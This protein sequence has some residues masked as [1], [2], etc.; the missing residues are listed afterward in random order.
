MTQHC[1]YIDRPGV[2][3]HL[4]VILC[5]NLKNITKIDA[6]RYKNCINY[7]RGRSGVES[8]EWK[9]L[10]DKKDVNTFSENFIGYL[11]QIVERNSNRVGLRYRKKGKKP[12][13]LKP[14]NKKNNFY[15]ELINHLQDSALKKNTLNIGIRY[16]KKLC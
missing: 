6:A 15:K 9:Y 11:H 8:M 5:L 14:I 10:I 3:D 1:A 4:L 7:H 12:N 2:K 13:I 16:K